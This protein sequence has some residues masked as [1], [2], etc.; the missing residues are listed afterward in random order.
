VDIIRVYREDSHGSNLDSGIFPT[1]N[2]EQFS[3]PSAKYSINKEKNLQRK[4]GIPR[5][6]TKRIFS[7]FHSKE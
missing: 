2:T 4:G 5:L 3:V 7:R 6:G 1:A